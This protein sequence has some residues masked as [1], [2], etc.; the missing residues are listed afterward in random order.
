MSPR[1]LFF[2]TTAVEPTYD[3]ITINSAY[4]ASVWENPASY[5]IDGNT[6]SYW[7]TDIGTS[8]YWTAGFNSAEVLTRLEIYCSSVIGGG[9]PSSGYEPTYFK[10]Q[11]S[12]NNSS[13]TDITSEIHLTWSSATWQNVEFSSNTTAYSYYRIQFTASQGS[14]AGLVEVK[15]YGVT[16]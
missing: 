15:A 5:A 11:G 7:R 1:W 3:Y 9:F 6:S 10:I 16:N 12:N 8:S 2:P 14:Y 4:V 13:F